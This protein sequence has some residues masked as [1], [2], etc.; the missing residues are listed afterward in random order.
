MKRT[1]IAALILAVTLFVTLAW[2]RISLEWSDSLPYEGEVTERRYLVLIL[3]AVTLFFGGCAT[4]IIA[5]RKLGTRH[6]RAS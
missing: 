2:V 5:F 6:S 4:A 1:L 3:V